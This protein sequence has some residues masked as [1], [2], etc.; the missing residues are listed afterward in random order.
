MHE[1]KSVKAK[2][3]SWTRFGNSLTMVEMIC[4]IF[5]SQKF[6]A[7]YL[8]SILKDP[9]HAQ[10]CLKF[11]FLILHLD[12]KAISHK[13]TMEILEETKLIKQDGSTVSAL[14]E[15]KGHI[16]GLY[17]SASWCPP[18][19]QFTPLLVKFYKELMSRGS[20]LKIIFVSSD[21]NENEMMTYF[22]KSHGDWFTLPYGDTAIE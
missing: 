13:L 14:D 4:Q 12:E 18:C 15:L 8:A 10:N 7:S 21:K 19:A 2:L 16:V 6:W 11:F 9:D 3:M 22:N 5:N 20:Q 1:A 17:F